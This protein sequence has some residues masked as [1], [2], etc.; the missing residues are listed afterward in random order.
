[1]TMNEKQAKLGEDNLLQTVNGLKADYD[2]DD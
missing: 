2:D 1:M